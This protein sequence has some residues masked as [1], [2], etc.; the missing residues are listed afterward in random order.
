MNYPVLA[1]IAR[2]FLSIIAT[3]APIEREFSK[4]AD[5]ANAKKRN[6]LIDYRINQLICLKSWANI[7]KEEEEN[8]NNKDKKGSIDDTSI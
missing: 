7:D 6:R 2:D 5:I 3:S 1:L 8:N 4:L